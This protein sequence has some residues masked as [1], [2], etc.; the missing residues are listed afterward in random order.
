MKRDHQQGGPCDQ[1]ANRGPSRAAEPRLWDRLVRMRAKVR[2]R[3]LAVLAVSA[4]GLAACGGEAAP[5][6]QADLARPVLPDCGIA[7]FQAG[8]PERHFVD[9]SPSGW[10]I[11]YTGKPGGQ[12]QRVPQVQ[13]VEE[14]P[15]LPARG[16]QGGR[17]ETVGAR[18][19]SMKTTTEPV[20]S[21]YA[22]WLTDRARYLVIAIGSSPA[23]LE[24][25]I[26]CLP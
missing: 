11:G 22:Q 20:T 4:V 14:S 12:A 18:R 16:V 24:R 13:L 5:E 19:V 7:G 6:P 1:P 21:R 15:E 26:R 2:F 23:E 3:G 9:G 25:L 8:E 17:W 10:K